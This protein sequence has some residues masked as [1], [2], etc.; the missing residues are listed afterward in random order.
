MRAMALC[1][2]RRFTGGRSCRLCRSRRAC[3][4]LPVLRIKRHGQQAAFAPE[5]IRS[6]VQE[7]R[8]KHITVL[9]N[10][11]GAGLLDDE[12]TGVAGGRGQEHRSRQARNDLLQ[13]PAQH[14]CGRINYRHICGSTGADFNSLGGWLRRIHAAAGKH[15]SCR[16]RAIAQDLQ[17]E[18]TRRRRQMR[19]IPRSGYDNLLQ[20]A[21]SFLSGSSLVCNRILPA[22]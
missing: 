15:A 6:N 3:T 20:T 18:R 1:Q 21:S 13:G 16:Y 7:R 19:P 5:V 8:S 12:Q 2:P 10:A 14:A 22:Y 9:H 17:R 11:Y 4:T